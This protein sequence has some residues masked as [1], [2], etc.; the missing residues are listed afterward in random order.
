MQ[1]VVRAVRRRPLRP[2][3]LTGELHS[4]STGQLLSRIG[5]LPP[6][7]V[8]LELLQP[9]LRGRF[10]HLDMTAAARDFLRRHP[11]MGT[12]KSAACRLAGL[13]ASPM[14]LGLYA[15]QLLTPH[16]AAR[17]LHEGGARLGTLVDVGAG[18]GLVSEPLAKL[19]R[20]SV[21]TELSRPCCL[22]LRARGITCV[23]G[24]GLSGE[25]TRRVRS[26][27][28]LKDCEGADVVAALN[29]L[30]RCAR[31]RE[32]LLQ[33]GE[34]AARPGGRVLLAL[35]LPVEQYVVTPAGATSPAEEVLPIGPFPGANAGDWE[36]ALN[37]FAGF[38]EVELGLVVECFSRV[39]YLCQGEDE[40]TLPFTALDDA[41][42][43][44]RRL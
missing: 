25:V 10:V 17:L 23:H 13:V 42:L 41:V 8:E 3:D 9:S 35:R 11:P 19:F 21:A 30:D 26:A 4:A 20:A 40:V 14:H 39:P 43:I 6:T 32:L 24:Q 12:V 29:V 15:M 16:A 27:L 36:R 18:P 2:G 1:A 37:A 33:M 31:P 44:C 28:C 5:F 34:L 38:L 7:D 22:R